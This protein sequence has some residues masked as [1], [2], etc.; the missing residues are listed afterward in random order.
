MHGS[1]IIIFTSSLSLHH[2]FHTTLS[3]SPFSVRV[4]EAGEGGGHAPPAGHGVGGLPRCFRPE[5][6]RG[7]PAVLQQSGVEDVGNVF[8]RRG[9][10]LPR[11]VRQQLRGDQSIQG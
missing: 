11:A 2:H 5:E 9:L 4:L 8:V 7:V 6:P 10:V 3:I 1:I